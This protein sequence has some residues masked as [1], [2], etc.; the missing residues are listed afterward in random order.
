[1]N[2]ACSGCDGYGVVTKRTRLGIEASG[3]PCSKCGGTG[4]VNPPSKG[5]RRFFPR[6]NDDEDENP[7]IEML[8]RAFLRKHGH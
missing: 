2:E 6:R 7:D 1:M 4:K 3:N 8:T 5:G